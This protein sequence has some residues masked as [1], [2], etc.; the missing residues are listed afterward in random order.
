[1]KGE[2]VMIKKTLLFRCAVFV[3]TALTLGSLTVG[4]VSPEDV[5]DTV[6]HSPRLRLIHPAYL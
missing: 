6:L 5:A 1:M 4:A 3:L 2:P